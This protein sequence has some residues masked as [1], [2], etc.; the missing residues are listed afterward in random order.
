MQENIS[1]QQKALYKE[2]LS[3]G[4]N[5]GDMVHSITLSV[6]RKPDFTAAQKIQNN[7]SRSPKKWKELVL[8]ESKGDWVLWVLMW[9]T[10]RRAGAGKGHF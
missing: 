3:N 6:K 5:A 1:R 8:D 4:N 9:W 7:K 10:G 2:N